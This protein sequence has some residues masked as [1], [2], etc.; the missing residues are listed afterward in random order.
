VEVDPVTKSPWHGTASARKAAFA[1]IHAVRQDEKEK[2]SLG[3]RA[4]VLP[5]APCEAFENASPD[6]GGGDRRAMT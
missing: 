4:P 6:K 2:T 3:E 5:R 1:A